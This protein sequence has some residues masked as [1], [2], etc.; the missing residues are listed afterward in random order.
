MTIQTLLREVADAP[1][2]DPRIVRLADKGRIDAVQL[3]SMRE[4]RAVFVVFDGPSP[5]PATVVKVDHQPRYQPR[6]RA[7]HAALVELRD[8][9]ALRGSVPEPLGLSETPRRVVLAQSGLPGTPL[10]LLMRRRR[11]V[12]HTY[13]ETDHRLVLDW[14]ARL[15]LPAAS[16]SVVLRAAAVV[17][18][19]TRGMDS[20]PDGSRFAREVSAMGEAFGD[21]RLPLLPGHGDLGTTNV[22]LDGRAVGVYDWEGG[23]GLRPPLPDLVLFLNHYARAL[24]T[25]AYRLPARLDAFGAAFLDDGWL[26]RLTAGSYFDYLRRLE[27]PVET[28]EWLFIATLAEL[29][30]ASAAIAH[31]QATTRFWTS[32]LHAY[33]RER[34]QAPIRAASG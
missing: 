10:N 24:P 30:G 20:V 34:S 3:G 4:G 14:L 29:A 1:F 7:E 32:A 31:A 25:S 26:G 16:E 28:A 6:L 33:A 23:S 22:V 18:A 17:E 9:D 8:R 13:A 5:T 19:V 12:A 2:T 21:I 11:R 15:H 27:L